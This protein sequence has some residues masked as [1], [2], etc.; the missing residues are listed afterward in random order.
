MSL[1]Q[2]PT[3]SII[4]SGDDYVEKQTIKEQDAYNS[5]DN[6]SKCQYENVNDEEDDDIERGSTLNQGTQ[7]N[8]RP[9]ILTEVNHYPSLNCGGVSEVQK[10]FFYK[11]TSDKTVGSQ[12][13]KHVINTA[14][15]LTH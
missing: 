14:C 4:F 13:S 7:H 3:Q 10:N 2:Q 15:T 11:S 12:H 8:L 9:L 1:I 6:P 5:Q